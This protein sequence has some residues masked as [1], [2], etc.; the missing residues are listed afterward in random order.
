MPFGFNVYFRFLYSSKGSLINPFFL[1]AS[2][3]NE[4]NMIK[5]KNYNFFLISK[6][7][8]LYIKILI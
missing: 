6:A 7:Y 5:P 2:V 3:Y 1:I 8:L 4:F